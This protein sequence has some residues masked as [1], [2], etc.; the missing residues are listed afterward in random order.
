MLLRHGSA[1][2]SS[3]AAATAMDHHHGASPCSQEMVVEADVPALLRDKIEYWESSLGPRA[4]TNSHRDVASRGPKKSPGDPLRLLRRKLVAAQM[5]LLAAD[6]DD[7]KASDYAPPVGD[8]AVASPTN[9]AVSCRAA[10]APVAREPISSTT[11]PVVLLDEVSNVVVDP[12][13]ATTRPVH[14]ARRGL[15]RSEIA[16]K[17]AARRSASANATGGTL[18]APD[19]SLPPLAP[20]AAAPAPPSAA[21]QPQ[22]GGS[23]AGGSNRPP[24]V[25][26]PVDSAERRAADEW[27]GFRNPF[28]EPPR[29]LLAV[30]P[31][32]DS[33]ARALP[34]R[35]AC[36]RFELQGSCGDVFVDRNGVRFAVGDESHPPRREDDDDGF[37]TMDDGHQSYHQQRSS[38]DGYVR[39]QQQ[40]LHQVV[41][42]VRRPNDLRQQVELPNARFSAAIGASSAGHHDALPVLPQPR[43]HHTNRGA[44]PNQRGRRPTAS[45]NQAAAKAD[46]S[47]GVA[48]HID[49]T[50]VAQQQ[51][52]RKFVDGDSSSYQLVARD[53]ENTRDDEPP[54]E[55][56]AAR[57]LFPNNSVQPSNDA[58]ASDGAPHRIRSLGTG[59]TW[60]EQ[61]LTEAVRVANARIVQHRLKRLLRRDAA[62]VT[63]QY[64]HMTRV[65][66]RRNPKR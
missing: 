2:S 39:E 14:S 35:G 6:D 63:S 18:R 7:S 58:G 36:V 1:S 29:R 59:L 8:S 45:R 65:A 28:L 17:I 56:Y 24:A 47:T 33:G 27:T 5:A 34:S 61:A 41:V 12:L 37:T 13:L 38:D 23:K 19:F 50:R 60:E 42:D 21:K 22:A 26:V 48:E 66:P 53:F 44:L 16:S 3:R 25:F 51:Q 49:S 40:H 20:S 9:R 64:G 4:E 15:S 46:S 11:G 57:R 62:A 32:V 55:G 31:K 52:R 43:T 54:T 30:G 10:S